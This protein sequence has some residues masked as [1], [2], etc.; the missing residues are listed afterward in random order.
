MT[1]A[2][3]SLAPLALLAL[4]GASAASA[5]SRGVS[6]SDWRIDGA[7]AEVQARVP[8]LELTRLQLHPAT[9]PDY[10]AQ[11]GALLAAR[12]QLGSEA[13]PCEPGPVA[14]SATAGWV[15]A[16]WTLRCGAGH[17]RWTVRSTLFAD[18]APSHLHF[19][20]MALA[21]GPP[22]EYVLSAGEP[23][24]TLDAPVAP[25]LARFAVLGL[26]H[27][28]GGADHLAF[29]LALILLA[30]GLGELALVA[31]GF[32]IAHS[33]TLG[34]AALGVVRV[35]A[36]AVEAVIGFSIALVAI[37]NLWLRDGRP[38]WPPRL[39]V[40]AL[41]ALAAA[42]ATR[43]SP[44]LL[45]GGALFTASYFALARQMPA[46]LRL[47]AAVAFVF[48]LVHG[49]GFAGALAPLDLPP[50][51]LLPALLGFNLGVEAGQLAVILLA[52]P[53]RVL[54][55]RMRAPAWTLD[56]VSASLCALGTFWFVSRA[57]S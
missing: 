49:F 7:Q 2:R 56:G 33:L 8:E 11:V 54:L 26:E 48:G 13:G 30:S 42:G 20:R 50:G 21:G 10:A 14:A 24:A 6:Y 45:G 3:R 31:T 41:L 40:A 29:V 28:L 22:Q 46:P 18:V 12:L 34:A 44:W 19:T 16:R 25:S 36:A 17:R 53:L 5:H 43:L 23:A 15:S 27:I 47:R 1:G 37:E 52:W 38:A 35:D 9:T 55:R 4:L 51:R 57:F 39:L 32:T